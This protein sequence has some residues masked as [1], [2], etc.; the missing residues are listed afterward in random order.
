[1]CRQ[2]ARRLAARGEVVILQEG[3]VMDPSFAK[4]VLELNLP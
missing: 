3:K 4:W 2:E 1:M